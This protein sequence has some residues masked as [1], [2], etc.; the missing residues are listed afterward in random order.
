MTAQCKADHDSA[1]GCEVQDDSNVRQPGPSHQTT[2]CATVW[3]FSTHIEGQKEGWK[4]LTR[5]NHKHA[6]LLTNFSENS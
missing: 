1:S 4:T 5:Q 3:D 6:Y 2:Q